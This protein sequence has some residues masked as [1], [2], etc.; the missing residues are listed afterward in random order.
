MISLG[1]GVKQLSEPFTFDK[2]TTSKPSRAIGGIVERDGLAYVHAGNIIQPAGVTRGLTASLTPQGLASGVMR[3]LIELRETRA[4]IEPARSGFSAATHT[5][6][7][8]R[9]QLKLC[10]SLN[11]PGRASGGIVE[12]DGMAHV[13]AGNIIQP[14][15]ITRGLSASLTPQGI[16]RGVLAHLTEQQHVAPAI[17]RIS[18]SVTKQTL[19]GAADEG[20]PAA[21]AGHALGRFTAGPITVHIHLPPGAPAAADPEELATL[22]RH[23]LSIEFER[24]AG[25]VDE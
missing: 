6:A 1:P 7:A 21:R 22:L 11:L 2:R 13:H 20:A 3:R 14:A 18:S 17:E 19:R 4:L 25:D 16:M 5:D 8:A 9:P 10:P 15:Q 12:R 23:R 24:A